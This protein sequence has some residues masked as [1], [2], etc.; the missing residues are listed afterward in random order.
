[1]EVLQVVEML[2]VEG[3]EEEG[4]EEVSEEVSALQ[5][6][7][8]LSFVLFVA[9]SDPILSPYPKSTVLGRTGGSGSRSD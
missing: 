1:M 8:L 5:Y 6:F 9:P 7:L 4:E 2:E 3:V